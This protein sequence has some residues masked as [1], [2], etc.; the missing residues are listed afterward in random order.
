[1][2]PRMISIVVLTEVESQSVRRKKNPRETHL[3]Q[4]SHEP[5]LNG[6]VESKPEL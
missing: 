1:M 3:Y 4:N 2:T 5:E 6:E